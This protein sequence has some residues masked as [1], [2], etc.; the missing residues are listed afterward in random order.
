MLI[1]FKYIYI[2]LRTVCAA[3]NVIA[4]DFN[5]VVVVVFGHS[6]RV[7]FILIFK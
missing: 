2:Y 6:A 5:A 4:D 1:R 3:V 7:Y